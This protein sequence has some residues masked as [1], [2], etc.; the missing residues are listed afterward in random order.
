MIWSKRPLKEVRMEERR[1]YVRLDTRLKI[2]YTV[3]KNELDPLEN[4]ETKD[5]GGGG[6]R[7]LLSGS[8][9]VQT[10]LRLNI[11][12]PEEERPIV[13]TGKV[14]WVEEFTVRD[15]KQY[16]AGVGFTEIDSRD[17]DRIIK[18][19]ILGYASVKK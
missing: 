4:S 8:L 17:R 7:I 10:L 11:L 19:V 12:L 16:E 15:K 2:S 18:Y 6:I 5:I 9:P 1:R 14:V 3:V 13:C